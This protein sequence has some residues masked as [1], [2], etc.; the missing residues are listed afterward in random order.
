VGALLG[1][2]VADALDLRAA[3]WVIAA[4]SVVSGVVVAARMR[5]E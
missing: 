3:A 1:G 2:V 5:P 4:L